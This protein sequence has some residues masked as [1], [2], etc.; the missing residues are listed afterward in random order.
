MLTSP[1]LSL[2]STLVSPTWHVIVGTNFGA[3]VVHQ[4]K[5][6]IYF[7]IS[8]LSFLMYKSG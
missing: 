8:P 1:P 4:T 2:C 5:N 7:C 6:Y 3:H